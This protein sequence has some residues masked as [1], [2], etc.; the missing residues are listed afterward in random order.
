MYGGLSFI[1]EAAVRRSAPDP[2]AD[3]AARSASIMARMADAQL[4]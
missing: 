4:P 1:I 3:L 2:S